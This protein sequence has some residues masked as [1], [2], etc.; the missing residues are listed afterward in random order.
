M[1]K[2]K[3][4]HIFAKGTQ[5]QLQSRSRFS[6][7]LIIVLITVRHKVFK[8]SLIYIS[9]IYNNIYTLKQSAVLE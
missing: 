2:W 4:K 8:S 9:P 7:C 5:N 1:P 6:V 3:K